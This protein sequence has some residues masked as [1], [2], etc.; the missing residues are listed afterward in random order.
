LADAPII[1][2]GVEAVITV[3]IMIMAGP[4]TVHPVN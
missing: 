3:T 1:T 4:A 2:T